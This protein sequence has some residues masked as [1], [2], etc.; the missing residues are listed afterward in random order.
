M[1]AKEKDDWLKAIRY[2]NGVAKDPER[3][4]LE[5]QIISEFIDSTVVPNLQKAGHNDEAMLASQG[6]THG[7]GSLKQLAVAYGKNIVIFSGQMDEPFVERFSVA[8]S[9][10]VL[11]MYHS[12]LPDGAG[13]FQE[14]YDYMWLKEASPEGCDISLSFLKDGKLVPTP[15]MTPMLLSDDE[16]L[17]QQIRLIG[18]FFHVVVGDRNR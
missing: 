2:P 8:G 6:R 13:N 18:T 7:E 15:G 10:G 5:E 16:V 14:H 9:K 11:N 3:V 17:A 1:S 12:I 4:T